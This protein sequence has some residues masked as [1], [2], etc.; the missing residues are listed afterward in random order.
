MYVNNVV[1][2]VEWFYY[3]VQCAVCIVY[4]PTALQCNTVLR[5][6]VIGKLQFS[7]SM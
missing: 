5:M 6:D 3:N 7:R 1:V 4:F 2:L